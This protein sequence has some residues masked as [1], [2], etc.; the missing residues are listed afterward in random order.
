M[1][2]LYCLIWRCYLI[3]QKHEVLQIYSK[4]LPKMHIVGFDSDVT[5]TFFQKSKPKRP[6]N[7]QVEGK[8]YF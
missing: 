1:T 2:Q 3:I 6:G 8:A 5:Q 4:K 7:I